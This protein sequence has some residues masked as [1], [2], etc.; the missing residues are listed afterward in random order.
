MMYYRL[1]NNNAAC[2]KTT[3]AALVPKADL[4]KVHTRRVIPA[5]RIYRY[6]IKCIYINIYILYTDCYY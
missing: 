2:I 3:L 1:Y 4:K 6:I 5:K